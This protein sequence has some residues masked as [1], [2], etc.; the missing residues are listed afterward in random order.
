MTEDD[1]E[2]IAVA[3]G[4]LG[5]LRAMCDGF[6]P[7]HKLTALAILVSET[8]QELPAL[9]SDAIERLKNIMISG[10]AGETKH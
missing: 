9:S 8:V 5:Q 1:S 7:Q 10:T 2:E 4:L 3:A 6:P